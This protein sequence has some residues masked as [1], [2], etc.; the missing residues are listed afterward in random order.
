MSG[1]RARLALL[2]ALATGT[3]AACVE[4]TAGPGGVQS[5]RL[6]RVPPSIIA[7]DVLRDSLGNE[8]RLRA[9]AFGA[10]GDSVPG[11]EFVYAFLPPAVDTTIRR[12]ALVVDPVTGAVRADTLPRPG[13][14]RVGARLGNALQ[15]FDSIAVVRRPTRLAYRAPADSVITL[16]Y[17][18]TDPGI[19]L[20]PNES[21]SLS[22]DSGLG[23]ASRMLEAR[24]TGDSLAA[25]DSARAAVP[26]PR[27]L[28]RFR[29]VSPTPIPRGRSPYGDERPAFYLINGA[30][31]DRPL[32]YDTT[33]AQGLTDV[34]LRVLPT[35]LGGAPGDTLRVVVEASALAGTTPVDSA[36]RFTVRLIRRA[37][38]T[39]SCP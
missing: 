32:G 8:V 10:G 35:L 33:N 25:T 2:A 18:C 16:R 26:V 9:V 34:R 38:S 20:A 7:G 6:Q 11:A 3:A 14:Q 28:V 30:G 27:Y 24:L 4:I 29:I 21:R 5:I 31:G 37:P 22:P 17:L 19:P 36:R 15:V 23:N 12:P 39:G 1:A 13:T